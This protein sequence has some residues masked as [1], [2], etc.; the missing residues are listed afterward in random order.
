MNGKSRRLAPAPEP[1]A[2]TVTADGTERDGKRGPTQA[3]RLVELAMS[4]YEL[5]RAPGDD[6][7]AVPRSGPRITRQL[8]GSGTSLRAELRRSYFDEIGTPP[9]Q[10]ALADAL[11]VL[12]GLAERRPLAQLCQ[13]VAQVDDRIVL[14]LGDDTG[15]AVV[16]GRGEWEVVDTPSAFFRRTP[17]TGPLPTPE[18]GGNLA[19]LKELLRLGDE[20]WSLVQGYELCCLFPEVEVPILYFKGPQGSGKSLRARL[21]ARLVDE[22]P[23]PLRSVPR[24][25]DW[26]AVASAARVHALDNVSRISEWFGDA[27]CRAT[28]GAGDARRALYTDGGL[29]I[30]S[31]KIAVI[32]TAVDVA[33]VPGDLG[34]RLLPI[35]VE[36]LDEGERRVQSELEAAFT[37]AHPRI[38]GALL[39]LLA[40]VLEV[41]PETK[42]KGLPR[43]AG[44]GQVYAAIDR[45]LGTTGFDSFRQTA[46]LVASDVVESDP[47][48]GAVLD[49]AERIGEW[50]GRWSELLVAITP[51]PNRV[52]RGW[53]ATPQGLSSH[54]ARTEEALRH[55]GVIVTRRR[56]K[57]RRLVHFKVESRGES[58]APAAPAAFLAQPGGFQG[59]E[60]GAADEGGV[61]LRGA[62][63]ADGVPLDFGAAA[64]PDSAWSSGELG[65]GA[66][67]VDHT[68][69][70]S[71]TERQKGGAAP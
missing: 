46:G 63:G 61:P 39:D 55:F 24:E 1:D 9:G 54:L 58:A 68:P 70:L 18:R 34:D 66:A 36:R 49:F 12:E 69:P 52:P 4:Q 28:T 57:G 16:I 38:L 23:A 50:E 41:M 44:A 35:E 2:E 67:G 13:R 3:R 59:A 29:A 64:P 31:H 45:V 22:S 60:R 30:F 53:P 71:E 15:R 26:P 40:S 7:Y 65:W 27:L 32:L 25:R 19:E 17:L 56:V 10:G 42:P 6:L 37:V 5:W 47:I 21:L 48:A 20:A 62:A 8:R 11:G 51:D 33:G 43:L 14:D